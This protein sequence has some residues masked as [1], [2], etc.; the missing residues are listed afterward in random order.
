MKDMEHEG[1]Q[2]LADLD[3]LME[4]LQHYQE[5]K[6][7]AVQEEYLEGMKKKME[8][9]FNVNKVYRQKDLSSA[10]L[11]ERLGTN[12]YYLSVLVNQHL[13]VSLRDYINSFRVIE[14][15]I[16]ILDR[17]SQHLTLEAI[18][19]LVG[20]Q[21]RSSFYRVFK[22]MTGVSPNVFKKNS[23]KSSLIF[24]NETD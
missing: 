4:K 12:T 8:L 13:K 17:K 3:R 24:Q 9:L 7:P 15:K 20:F 19:D 18:G 22:K 11:A 2:L 1:N 6:E 14:A 10:V 5:L 23:L 16:L 21:S